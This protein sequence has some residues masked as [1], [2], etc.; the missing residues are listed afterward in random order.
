MANIRLAISALAIY[1]QLA[2][3]AIPYL[4]AAYRPFG[5]EIHVEKGIQLQADPITSDGWQ[6]LISHLT[7]SS[8]AATPP[9]PAHVIFATVPPGLDRSINGQLLNETRGLCALFLGANSFQTPSPFK[10]LDLVAQ[11]LIHEVGHMLNLTHG[12]SYGFG[13]SDSMMPTLE[14]QQQAPLAAWQAALADAALRH[15]LPLQIPSPTYYYPFAAQCRACLR[16][17]ATDPRWWPWRSKFRDEFSNGAGTQSDFSLDISIDPAS[18]PEIITTGDGISFTLQ[19][20]NG[21]EQPIPIPMHIGPEFGTMSVATKAEGKSPVLFKPDNYRCSSGKIAVLP[22]ETVLR[23][24]SLIPAPGESLFSEAGTHTLQVELFTSVG[25]SRLLAG[26]A[27]AS[28]SIVQP[29]AMTGA[30]NQVAAQLVATIRGHHALPTR[31]DFD[32]LHSLIENSTIAQH[33]RYKLAMLHSGDQRVRL[34][35][36]CLMPGAPTAVRHRAARQLAI[37]LLQ[38]GWKLSRVMSS[39]RRYRLDERDEELFETLERMG[40]GWN[41]LLA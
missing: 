7:Q 6:Q 20:R 9:V 29:A 31:G 23:S 5:I 38:S 4:I 3:A 26:T 14:R 24:F 10:R 12:D 16:A 40:Q 15:E 28:I 17:A 27:V 1:E 19:I 22:G 2:V 13:H 34:L 39:M 32:K 11:V 37:H 35:K 41:T 21:G 18:L 36:E 30:A 8:S 33:A 25:G